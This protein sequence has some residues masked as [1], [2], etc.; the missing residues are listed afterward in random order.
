MKI[1]DA[2]HERARKAL[3]S[4]CREGLPRFEN[5]FS[6]KRHPGGEKHWNGTHWHA[7][8]ARHMPAGVSLAIAEAEHEATRRERTRC[9]MMV[10]GDHDII[11]A[12]YDAL[13]SGAATDRARLRCTGQAL[14][15]V[16]A[17]MEAGDE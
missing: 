10:R 14:A 17:R 13:P 7:C 1:T 15:R 6:G 4:S 2:H 9:V 5:D 8:G 11:K 3:C 16:L 12:E